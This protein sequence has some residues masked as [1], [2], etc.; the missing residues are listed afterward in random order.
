MAGKIIEFPGVFKSPRDRMVDAL[1][2]KLERVFNNP[3]NER[4]RAL[5]DKMRERID[6]APPKP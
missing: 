2:E 4:E 3:Q 1:A 6:R 5:A